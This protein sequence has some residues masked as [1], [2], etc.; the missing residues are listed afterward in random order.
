MTYRIHTPH[1]LTLLL[2]VLSLPLH[3]SDIIDRPKKYQLTCA[4]PYELIDYQP[5]SSLA[6]FAEQCYAQRHGSGSV[7]QFAGMTSTPDRYWIQRSNPQ[8][9]EIEIISVKAT[10]E[11]ADCP[12]GYN[13]VGETQCE[14]DPDPLPDCSD[15]EG[16]QESPA[17]RNEYG[18]PTSICMPNQCQ[19]VPE[20]LP[21]NLIRPGISLGDGKTTYRMEYS[22]DACRYNSSDVSKNYDLNSP[23]AG[24]HG[25]SSDSYDPN[26]GN[27]SGGDFEEPVFCNEE[28]LGSSD[29]PDVDDPTGYGDGPSVGDG[30][31]DGSGDGS[32]S[33]DGTGN[34]SGSGAGGR[35]GLG[36]FGAP[37]GGQNPWETILN[38]EDIQDVKHDRQALEEQI[39]Q[40]I[41]DI[42]SSI[43][44]PNLAQGGAIPDISFNLTQG[45]KSVPVKFEALEKL[46]PY[47]EAAL[48]LG[49]AFFSFYTVLRR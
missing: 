48:L 7:W 16:Q 3:A 23:V 11:W 5:G 28:N 44:A 40:R 22:G 20:K 49:A 30:T 2:G 45:G 38:G 34:G 10:S 21:N 9:L 43:S 32:G 41:N 42:K 36:L 24:G 6:P 31:P 15:K 8:K 35:G 25:G 29:C 14:K 39:R 37:V 46:A 47:I 4:Q 27:S 1:L 12:Q 17:I 13:L 33:G 18:R 26:A 19:L